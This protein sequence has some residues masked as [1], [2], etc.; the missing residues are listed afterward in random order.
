[1]ANLF[2]SL[3]KAVKA[4]SSVVSHTVDLTATTIS[5]LDRGVVAANVATKQA[6]KSLPS[7]KGVARLTERA[8]ASDAESKA[9]K[10]ADKA[11]TV[12]LTTKFANDEISLKDLQKL[13]RDGGITSKM[14]R[15]IIKG[16]SK[17]EE[18]ATES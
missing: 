6:E 5:I 10:E 15:K 8:L 17:K 7:N 18:P 13:A 4:A 12:K 14:M 2:N 3:S 9:I 1:M 11:L 16:A